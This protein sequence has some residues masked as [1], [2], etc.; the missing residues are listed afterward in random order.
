[1][2]MSI[3]GKA[4]SIRSLDNVQLRQKLIH[5]Q[6]ELSRYKQV[7]EKYQ[8][9]YH[10][11]QL[12][13]L[14]NDIQK[15]EALLQQKNE[16]ISQLQKLNNEY[17]E[18]IKIL[19]EEKSQFGDTYS[20]LNEKI[21]QI[22]NENSRLIEENELVNIENTSLRKTLDDQE[23][24]VMKLREAVEVSERDKSIF[25][26]SKTTGQFKKEID[27][28]DSWFLRTLKQQNKDNDS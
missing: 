28:S 27:P 25:K 18:Q 26:P 4:K 14:K 21:K 11:N 23:E 22:Q 15:L 13:D 17:E 24:E 1:M 12:D 16:E 8:N 20:E 2:K 19:V 9:N 6:A 5:L 10:Y 7:V 3:E